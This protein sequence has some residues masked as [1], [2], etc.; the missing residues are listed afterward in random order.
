MSSSRTIRTTLKT[1]DCGGSLDH[2]TYYTDRTPYGYKIRKAHI[3]FHE[4]TEME[5]FF[6]D[7]EAAF[8]LAP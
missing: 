7:V 5:S 1:E 6:A 2:E 3:T 4:P 8:D